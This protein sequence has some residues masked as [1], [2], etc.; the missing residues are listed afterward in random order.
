M[1]A[2]SARCASGSPRRSGSAAQDVL[3]RLVARHVGAGVRRRHDGPRHPQHRHA[4]L[5]HGRAGVAH[6]RCRDGEARHRG[7]GHV[8]A[9][10]S[11]SAAAPSARSSSPSTRRTTAAA[12]RSSATTCR[13]S[14]RSRRTIRRASRSAST[15]LDPAAAERARD[16]ATR[17]VP[18]RDEAPARRDGARLPQRDH[19][20]ARAARHASTSAAARWRSSPASTSPR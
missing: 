5:A 16:E 11:A 17:R 19:R 18:G 3:R 4:G 14:R 10:P 2:A 6:R 13:P 9:R 20:A 7:R 1:P 12:S 8:C 15:S